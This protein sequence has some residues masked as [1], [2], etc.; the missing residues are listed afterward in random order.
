MDKKR[1]IRFLLD[2]TDKSTFELARLTGEKE[3]DIASICM[4][5]ED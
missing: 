4:E 2:N 3:E 5:K 1:N